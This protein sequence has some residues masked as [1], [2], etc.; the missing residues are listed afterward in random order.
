M[1]EYEP[2]LGIYISKTIEFPMALTPGL[3]VG[4]CHGPLG[5]YTISLTK[6]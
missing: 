1:K 6:F 2:K 3:A 5:A 4:V